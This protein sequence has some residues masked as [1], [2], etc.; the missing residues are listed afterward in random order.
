MRKITLP[1]ICTPLFS[2]EVEMRLPGSIF[3]IQK[4]RL[5]FYLKFYH[6]PKK[7]ENREE[8]FLIHYPIFYLPLN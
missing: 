6:P 5:Q 3:W 7:K 4:K 8:S 1:F 2:D